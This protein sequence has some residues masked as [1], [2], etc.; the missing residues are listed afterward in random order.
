MPITDFWNGDVWRAWFG[1]KKTKLTLEY[2][3]ETNGL[4]VI[5][6]SKQPIPKRFVDYQTPWEEYNA[7]KGW[8]V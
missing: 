3:E 7:T 8:L 4:G 6:K 2:I 1:L 5:K